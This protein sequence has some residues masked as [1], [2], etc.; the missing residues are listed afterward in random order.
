MKI[1]I[2]GAGKLGLRITEILKGGDHSIT[3]IDK[4]EDLIRRL[5]NTLDVSTVAG[6][7]KE[8]SLLEEIGI[9]DYVFLIA[10]SDS[11]EKIILI[12]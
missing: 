7:A 4:D 8:I 9:K 3:L 12:V 2:A 11:V 5:S 6:N 10:T 1:A